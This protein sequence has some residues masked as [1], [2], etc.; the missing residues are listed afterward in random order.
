MI[1]NE[2]IKKSLKGLQIIEPDPVFKRSVRALV[3]SHQPRKAVAFRLPVFKIG[4]VLAVIVLVITALTMEFSPT[5]VLSSSFNP[6][7]L[8]KEFNSLTIN[9]Q[10]EEA[11]YREEANKTIASALN[12]IENTS[13][14]HLN[15]S[16][17]QNEAGNLEFQDSTNPE[18]DML[19]ET[20]IN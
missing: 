4:S 17:L 2:K 10:F 11:E 16:L 19:L 18:I 15:N 13:V 14:K 6:G 5:P 3:L 12:E 8:E 1:T 20:V 9:V 7:S